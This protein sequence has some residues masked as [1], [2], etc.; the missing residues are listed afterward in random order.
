MK[1]TKNFVLLSGNEEEWHWGIILSI[2]RN[3]SFKNKN[4]FQFQNFGDER[5]LSLE[6]QK[7]ISD[8]GKKYYLEHKEH[9]LKQAKKYKKTERGKEVESNAAQKYRQMEKAK[10]ASREY[11]K[12]YFETEKGK[13]IQ[14]KSAR[15]Y[16]KTEKGRKVQHCKGD[17]RRKLGFIELNEEFEGSEA[18]HIDKEFILYTPKEIHRSICHNVWTG[19]GMEKINGL[20]F[21]FAYGIDLHDN[22]LGES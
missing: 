9:I 20:A 22:S 12:K 17:K 15:K 10:K 11:N 19:Q 21:E 2:N 7:R 13:E 8:Y 14:R 5:P 16:S 3:G 6:T 18:H 4:K 1:K